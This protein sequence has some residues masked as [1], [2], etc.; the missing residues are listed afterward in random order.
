MRKKLLL[1]ISLF[2]F[3]FISCST[4]SIASIASL[5]SY[6]S[7]KQQSPSTS[8]STY[9]VWGRHYQV[10]HSSKNYNER[11][12]ASWYGRAFHRK[13]TSSGERYNMYGM[14]AAHKSLPLRTY[15]QVTNLSNGRQVVVKVNDRG[16]FV[17]NRLIDLSYAAAQKLG[18]VG[19]GLAPV[20]IKALS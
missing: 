14:T 1:S 5:H 20:S 12:I 2:L 8:K 18:M 3:V 6:S 11:G 10:M 4:N 19:R 16:P 13:I 15:V 17:G 9:R 7:T